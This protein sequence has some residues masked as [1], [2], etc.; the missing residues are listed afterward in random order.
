M[1]SGYALQIGNS[2]TAQ[3]QMVDAD[4]NDTSVDIDRLEAEAQTHGP[5]GDAEQPAKC[6]TNP[7]RIPAFKPNPPNKVGP[8]HVLAA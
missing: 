4:A 8:G 5:A 6:F 1:Q 3:T 2:G 7:I